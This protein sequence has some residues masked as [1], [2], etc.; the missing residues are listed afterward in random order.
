MRLETETELV[1]NPVLGGIIIWSF[2]NAYDRQLHYQRGPQLPFLLPILP[3]AF[4]QE[5]VRSLQGRQRE[6][7][8]DLALTENRTLTLDLQERMESMLSQ[9]M[10][11]LNLS[12]ASKLISY[13]RVS[14]QLRSERRTPPFNFESLDLRQMMRTANRLGYWFS[15]ISPERICFSL[16][17]RF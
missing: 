5:T 12:L 9:S 11:A 17:I 6:G 8:L 15:T 10:R 7:G 4:H 14:G 2:V 13:D 3:M 1:Q 16:R